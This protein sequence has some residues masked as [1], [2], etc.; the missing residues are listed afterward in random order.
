M[1]PRSVGLAAP[2]FVHSCTIKNNSSG[3]IRVQI[4]YKG[5][6]AQGT[7]DHQETSVADIPIGGTYQAKERVT[8]HGSYQTRKE[9][10]GIK[11]VRVNGQK[12]QL[13]APFD[14]VNGVELNWLFIID[15]WQIHSL[16]PNATNGLF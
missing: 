7:G 8:N 5:P 14:G 3:P 4:L 16:N 9:I 2:R 12:H 10:A 1:Y 13:L 11:V 6:A 15:N